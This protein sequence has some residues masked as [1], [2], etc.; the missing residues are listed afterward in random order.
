MLEL[1]CLYNNTSFWLFISTQYGTFS[2]LPLWLNHWYTSNDTSHI[3]HVC[4]ITS[5]ST[6]SKF[7]SS[8][9]VLSVNHPKPTK[10]LDG[11]T[12]CNWCGDPSRG[13]TSLQSSSRMNLLALPFSDITQCGRSWQGT[14][15]SEQGALSVI[16]SREDLLLSA[17]VYLIIKV[18]VR[19][20]CLIV[21]CAINIYS[22]EPQNNSTARYR[23]RG[24]CLQSPFSFTPF[25]RNYNL[26]SLL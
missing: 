17:V 7:V 22:T 25:T 19:I 13:E 6:L 1:D 5:C 18:K 4:N 26:F 23:A 16:L 11:L 2:S 12:E 10:G 3:P 21:R 8:L 9:I 20:R 24:P 15:R 14:N